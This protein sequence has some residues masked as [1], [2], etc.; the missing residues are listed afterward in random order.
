MFTLSHADGP[1]VMGVVNVTADSF[2]DGGRYL[3]VDAAVRH[4]LELHAA[5]VD[6][7]DVG[8]SRHVREPTASTRPSRRS[9][10]HR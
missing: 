5:G 9:A 4:G 10:S 8:A 1:V 7:V 3:D 2:S 6:I